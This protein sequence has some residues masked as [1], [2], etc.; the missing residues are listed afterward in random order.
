LGETRLTSPPTTASWVCQPRASS[1][2]IFSAAL[3][4]ADL[5][6]PQLSHISAGPVPDL[7]FWAF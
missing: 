4:A 1:A 5:V 6:D 2:Q 7:T 3:I